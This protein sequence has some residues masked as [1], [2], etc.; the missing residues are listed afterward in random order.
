MGKRILI[1]D[2]DPAIRYILDL[3]L[4]SSSYSVTEAVDGQEALDLILASLESDE[5]YD[6]LLTD[7]R[8]PRMTGIDLINALRGKGISIP[9]LV[10]TG[11]WDVDSVKEF[12]QKKCTAYFYKPLDIR[13]LLARVE[14]IMEET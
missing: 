8:M 12:L 10:I 7:I 14:T 6:L 2:D 5:P 4:R 1:V 9:T 3:A 13:E 11:V